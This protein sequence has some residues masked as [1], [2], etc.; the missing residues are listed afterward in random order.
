MV[1]IVLVH[2][3][4]QE[5]RSA[6][7][8]EA[9]WVPALAG[10]V[11]NAG[12]PE[13]ADR[14]WRAQRPG[15]L[16]TRMAFYGNEF[17]RKGSQGATDGI[18]I[19]TDDAT[20][21]S[22]ATEWLE[23][24]TESCNER[25]AG[26]A[27]MELAALRATGESQG[28]RSGAVLAVRG[29]DRIPWMTRGGLAVVGRFN[30][31]ITQVGAYMSN[32]AVRKKVLSRVE[33]LLDSDPKIVVSHSLGSV[34]AYELLRDRSQ[35]IP[36]FITLGSPLGLR[37]IRNRLSKGAQFPSVEKWINLVDRNDIVAARP[38]IQRFF[39]AGR[40]EAALFE[41]SYTVDNGSSPHDARFYLG[42]EVVGSAIAQ[43]LDSGS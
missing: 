10:G 2:G 20:I 17:I 23:N 11:R 25:D 16:D 6:D 1:D 19:D 24:A 34:V 13:L 36:L 8:L 32:D 14:L 22:L 41:S 33:A 42:K 31:A 35:R 43:L 4:A 26:N 29:I 3:I 12:F 15:S 9:E 5:Q 7:A 39:D 40:P 30:K 27:A 37:T 18:L 28:L 21:E 38:N